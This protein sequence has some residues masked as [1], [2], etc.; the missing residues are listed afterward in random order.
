MASKNRVAGSDMHVEPLAHVIQHHQDDN[1]RPRTT[2]IAAT[3][4]Q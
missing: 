1:A 4:L 3:R 2:S